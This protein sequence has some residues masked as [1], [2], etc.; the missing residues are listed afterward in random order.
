MTLFL[1]EHADSG[2]NFMEGSLMAG[3]EKRWQVRNLFWRSYSA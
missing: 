3:F 1:G 2:V